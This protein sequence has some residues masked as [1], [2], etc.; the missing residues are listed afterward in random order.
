MNARAPDLKNF[1]VILTEDGE[2]AIVDFDPTDLSAAR[3]AFFRAC[4]LADRRRERGLSVGPVCVR[5]RI[6]GRGL[7]WVPT[8]AE[9]EAIGIA[10]TRDPKS[11]VRRAASGR[12]V[13]LRA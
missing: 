6:S 5:H 8:L 4:R 1:F 9:L 13:V 10:Y 12:W 3:E 7:W 2:N 11:P